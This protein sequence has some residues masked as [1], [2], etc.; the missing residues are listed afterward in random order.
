MQKSGKTQT[1][2]IPYNSTR[3]GSCS[4]KLLRERRDAG[5]NTRAHFGLEGRTSNRVRDRVHCARDRRRLD[6]DV[7]A[8]LDR[9]NRKC[10][11][12]QDEDGRRLL[13]GRRVL[14]L[15][16][17][18]QDEDGNDREPDENAVIEIGHSLLGGGT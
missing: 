15:L 10:N 8:P 17:D 5:Q 7:L 3:S 16:E 13:L 2:W 12:R 1:N 11:R 4:R 9:A 18:A 6:N 14:D